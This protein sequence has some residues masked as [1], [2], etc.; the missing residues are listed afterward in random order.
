MSLAQSSRRKLASGITMVVANAAG[1]IAL[2][3]RVD[4]SSLEAQRV[5]PTLETIYPFPIA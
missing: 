1:C 2:S 3:L 5:G 4:S